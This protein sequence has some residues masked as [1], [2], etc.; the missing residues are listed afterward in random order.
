MALRADK[1]NDAHFGQVRQIEFDPTAQ[2]VVSL[3]E[4]DYILNTFLV[5]D[6]SLSSGHQL[7]KLRDTSARA[8][9]FVNEKLVV[10]GESGEIIQCEWPDGESQK[11]LCSD[12]G[13]VQFL[14]AASKIFFATEREV[15]RLERG[16]KV[17]VF[18]SEFAIGWIGCAKT[19]DFLVVFTKNGRLFVFDDKGEKVNQW[20]ITQNEFCCPCIS[21]NGEL[22]VVD[23]GNVRVFNL[24]TRRE[25]KIAISGHDGSIVAIATTGA[26]F[27]TADAKGNIIVWE[28]NFRKVRFEADEPPKGQ[29]VTIERQLQTEGNGVAT[30]SFGGQALVVGDVNGG[31]YFWQSVASAVEEPHKAP[32]HEV[33]KPKNIVKAKA[34]DIMSALAKPVAPK[35]KKKVESDGEVSL[36]D[37]DDDD[38]PMR[39]KVKQVAEEHRAALSRLPK[40]ATKPKAGKAKVKKL[41]ASSL[42][43][44]EA[45]E[46]YES[47]GEIESDDMEDSAEEQEP[48]PEP[49]PEPVAEERFFLPEESEDDSEADHEIDIE[50]Y[51]TDEQRAKLREKRGEVEIEDEAIDEPSTESSSEDADLAD[52]YPDVTFPFMP[53]SC[54]TFMGNRRYMCWNE[55]AAV[56]LRNTADGSIIDIHKT[57]GTTQTIPNLGYT[58]ATIDEYGLMT[59]SDAEVTYRHHKSWAPDSVTTIS[60]ARAG[61]KVRL[62]ACGEEWFAVATDLPAIRVFTSA[63]FEIGC[64][65]LPTACTVMCGRDQYLFYAYGSALRYSVVDVKSYREIVSGTMPV[66]QPL[67]WVSIAA[68]YTIVCQDYWNVVHKLS[69]DFSWQWIP[70]ANLE[71]SFDYDTTGFWL[72]SAGEA[73]VYGVNLRGTKSPATNPIPGVKMVEIHPLIVEPKMRP[74]LEKIMNGSMISRDQQTRADAELLKLFPE[75]VHEDLKLEAFQLAELMKTKKVRDFVITFADNHNASAIADHLTGTELKQKPK[76]PAVAFDITQLRSARPSKKIPR[77]SSEEAM[78]YVREAETEEPPKPAEEAPKPVTSLMDAF[79][80]I[81]NKKPIFD[82][83]SEKTPEKTRKRK[84]SEPAA[85]KP[86]KSGR[87]K[88]GDSRDFQPL[89]S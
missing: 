2:E 8:F 9:S 19:N 47:E 61:E 46:E 51:L 63:G 53:G 37:N 56:L 3:G 14:C 17:S 26:S 18:E 24:A 33:G 36:S 43:N 81:G 74:W 67:R 86:K 77:T 79:K 68:D 48:E 32:V 44:N 11:V 57:D 42:T 84:A 13:A 21:R 29:N 4:D 87:K 50:P 76:K 35:Q 41:W 22:F 49:E 52:L 10:V 71:R 1:T 82:V 20:I 34:P 31:I 72:V 80:E 73:A 75:S 85:P 65:E 25:A 30:M 15:F 58:L 89:F 38:E 66:K 55:Y 62:I 5:P 6:L 59:A 88:L 27:A 70:V 64:F 12:C 69:R 39:A 60:F 54:D 16:E 40:K 28:Y 78:V 45:Y 7:D 23:D 83:Q